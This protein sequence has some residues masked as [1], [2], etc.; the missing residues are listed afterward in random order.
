MLTVRTEKKTTGT[1][2]AKSATEV[3]AARHVGRRVAARPVRQFGSGALAAARPAAQPVAGVGGRAVDDHLSGLGVDRLPH[4]TAHGRR[5]VALRLH[6]RVRRRFLFP[7]KSRR[8]LSVLF[9]V[10]FVVAVVL[11]WFFFASATP[12]VLFFINST[13]PFPVN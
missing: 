8:V 1:G 13:R 7:P 10:G 2:R 3:D 4:R 11:F 5:S 6:H 9:V 12:A